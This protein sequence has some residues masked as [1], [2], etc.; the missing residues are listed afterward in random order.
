MDFA[1]HCFTWRCSESPFWQS[2]PGFN[3]FGQ[4][5]S[6][7][8]ADLRTRCPIVVR[9]R[10][11]PQHELLDDEEHSQSADE[12]QTDAVVCNA[13]LREVIGADFLAA[14]AGADHVAPLGPDLFLLLFEL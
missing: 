13:V 5:V 11:P 10:V 7:L 14:V 6:V 12:R 2:S 4:I 9:M 8:R 3:G 1:W